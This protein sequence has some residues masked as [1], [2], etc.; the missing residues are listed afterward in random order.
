MKAAFPVD[1][2]AEKAAYEI[3]FGNVERPT[4]WNTSWDVA[5]FEVCGHRWADLSEGGYG[6][7]LMNDC[8]YGYDIKDGEIRLTLLKSG[9]EPN[10]VA[11]QEE[12]WFTYSIYPH[13]GDWKTAST[14]RAAYSLNV[15]LRAEVVG[16]TAGWKPSEKPVHA[17][18]RR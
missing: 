8:K 2:N 6:V 16:A 13:A 14:T 4:H 12:H 18:N 3:Q 7:S 17:Q 15:P 11:D 5:R 9:I 1:V 10:P